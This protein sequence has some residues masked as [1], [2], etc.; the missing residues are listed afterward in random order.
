MFEKQTLRV[1]RSDP[2]PCLGG[3]TG[4]QWRVWN[5]RRAHSDQHGEI[6]L[7]LRC[8]ECG[9]GSKREGLEGY[10]SKYKGEEEGSG[11]KTKAKE[12]KFMNS[13]A[14]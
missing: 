2:G 7:R 13:Q 4:Q 1:F 5:G 6:L 14:P 3:V 12:M 10:G 9:A 8:E 11:A